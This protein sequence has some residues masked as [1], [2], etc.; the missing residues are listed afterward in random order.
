MGSSAR[1]L[2]NL[3]TVTFLCLTVM[4]KVLAGREDIC[5]MIQTLR[6]VVRVFGMTI[7]RLV[8]VWLYDETAHK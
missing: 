6:I 7:Q 4:E 1:P 2:N 5:Q 3:I 8:I